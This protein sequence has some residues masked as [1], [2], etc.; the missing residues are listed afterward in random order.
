MIGYYV[1]HH[2]RGHLH[3]AMVVTA[4]LSVTV[5]GLSS[6]P[7]PAGWDGPWIQLPRD[8]AGD[9]P[10]D[11]EA[12]GRLHWVPAHDPGLRGRMAT[13]GG[14]IEAARPALLMVDV[15]VEVLLLARL[16][17]IPV[18]TMVLPGDR[19]DAGHVLAHGVADRVLAVW[20]PDA[21]E[22]VVGIPHGV[23]VHRVGALSRF[24]TRIGEPLLRPSGPRRRV[25]VLAGAGGSN[26]TPRDVAEARAQTPEWH[27][28]ILDA[29]SGRWVED[30]WPLLQNADVIVTHGGQNALAEVAAARRPAIVIPQA[31]PH[32]EQVTTARVLARSGRWPAVAHA[33]FASLEWAD[34]LSTAAALPGEDWSGWNDGHAAERLAV[35]LEHELERHTSRTSRPTSRVTR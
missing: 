26:L 13:I 1:H 12:H 8:D 31:R 34:R 18:V 32:A 9:A 23:D 14:W 21:G 25:V 3:R 22:M 20:P 16:H 15:S 17:G 33:T 30:P 27:W 28:D 35:V 7:R 24:D 11:P 29:R 6:L 10:T 4:Q 2:G 19:R 5:T